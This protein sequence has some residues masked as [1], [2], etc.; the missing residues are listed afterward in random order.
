MKSYDR[1][2]MSK[3]LNLAIEYAFIAETKVHNDWS[4]C[5]VRSKE[6]ILVVKSCIYV[7][8]HSLGLPGSRSQSQ[9]PRVSYI[10]SLDCTP[11]GKLDEVD[12]VKNRS[13]QRFAVPGEP[14]CVVCGKYG[15]YVCD[16]VGLIYYILNLQQN[17]L[18]CV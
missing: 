5:K 18:L 2:V 11:S 13:E 4:L 15:E 10:Q 3:R 7:L 12:R 9:N 6:V 16:E 8:F 14:V 17:T 1:T